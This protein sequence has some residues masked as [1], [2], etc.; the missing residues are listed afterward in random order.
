MKDIVSIIVCFASL[1]VAAGCGDSEPTI[2]PGQ[3][4]ANPTG[5]K[6]KSPVPVGQSNQTMPPIAKH[7][8]EMAEK[9]NAQGAQGAT[10]K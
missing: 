9:L 7:A 10:G 6:P 4:I 5:F 8:Q 1:V 2:P 3:S